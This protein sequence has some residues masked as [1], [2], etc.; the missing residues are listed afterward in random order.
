MKRFTF[1]TAVLL[2]GALTASAQETAEA[3]APVKET[4]FLEIIAAGGV[5]MYPL[6]LISVVGVVLVLLYLLTIRRNAVV[7]DR[8]MNAEIGRAHV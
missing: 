6:A 8:F 3:A 5:M 1:P 4:N 2:C 7:S